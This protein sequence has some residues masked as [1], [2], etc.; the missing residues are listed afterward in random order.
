MFTDIGTAQFIKKFSQMNLKKD[1]WFS[2]PVPVVNTLIQI[3]KIYK[4]F[5]ICLAILKNT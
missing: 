4:P 2:H 5:Q 1:S 3:G